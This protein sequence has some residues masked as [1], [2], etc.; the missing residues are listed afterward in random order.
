MFR[1]SRTLLVASVIGL[2]GF[3][4]ICYLIVRPVAQARKDLQLLATTQVGVTTGDEFR[5]MAV[6]SGFRLNESLNTYGVTY[7]NRI[8]QYFHLAPPTILLMN[9]R[10]VGGVVEGISVRGDVGRSREF[11]KIS[12]DERDAHQTNCGDM[13]VCIQ[14]TSSTTETI[15]FFH[16]ATPLARREQLLSLN[17]W[18]LAKLGGCRSNRELFPGVWQGEQR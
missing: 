4:F 8:L 1:K 12:I 17:T 18:C 10:I 9:A 3:G 6:G 11:A 16:P 7:H 5:K 14:Q 13:P 2:L 15:V